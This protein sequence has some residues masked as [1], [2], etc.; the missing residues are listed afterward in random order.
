VLQRECEDFVIGDAAA[1]VHPIEGGVPVLRDRW[2]CCHLCFLRFNLSAAFLTADPP[3]A[4]FLL[5][6]SAFTGVVKNGVSSLHSL[7]GNL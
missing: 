5:A 7:V 4:A 2:K 3:K 6:P 1:A